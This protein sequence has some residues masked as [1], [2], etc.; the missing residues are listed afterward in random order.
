MA[1]SNT[2]TFTDTNFEQEV[3]K[4]PI[5]ALVDFWAEWCSPC[6]A[7]APT[8]DQ[9]ASDYAGK[10]KVGKLDIDAFGPVAMKYGIQSIPTVLIFKG[11]QVVKK[12]VGAQPK[13]AI[14][15]AIDAA[16]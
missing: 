10:A 14:A 3:L 6:R 12:F 11:G 1:G 9:L 2:L 16:L 13:A 5:P 15:A 7:L 4:S 8:I